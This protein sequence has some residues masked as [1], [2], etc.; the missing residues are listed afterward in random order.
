V[1]V[2]AQI[3]FDFDGLALFQALDAQRTARGLSWRQVADEIWAL[4]AELND[5]R[6]DHP[7]S[8]STITNIA[9]RRATSCQHALFFLR[10][11]G[12]TPESFLAAPA[13]QVIE[14]QL[15]AAGPD[16]RLRW[17]LRELYEALDE[18]RRA[19]Q[20]TWAQLARF[21]GCTPNQLT[22]LRTARFGTGMNIAM[23]IVQWLER[24]AA[25]FI[26]LAR[27]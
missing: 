21:M 13:G 26:Y 24:P 10:W 19:E 5:R 7:I 15:P 12:R 4:S 3:I 23:S 27:W 6:R 11:L 17:N 8:P 25:D 1:T 2:V 22:A 9:K 14:G 20:L 18:C 16:R